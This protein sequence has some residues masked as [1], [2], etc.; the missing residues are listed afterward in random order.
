[1]R[2]FNGLTTSQVEQ[3]RKNF[4]ANELPKPKTATFWEKY[5]GNFNDPIITILLV[6]LGI[7]IIF[8][9]L[10][11]VELYEAGGILLA[12][13]ISTFVSTFSEYKNEG[14]FEK[15]QEKAGQKVC[16]VYR[17]GSLTEIPIESLVV[18]DFVWLCAGDIVPADGIVIDGC[19][20]VDQSPLN[21]EN[22]EIEKHNIF[23]NTDNTSPGY[24]PATIHSD[25]LDN[26]SVFRGSVVQSGEC[27]AE[28]KSVGGATVYG[29]MTHELGADTRKS[30]LVVKLTNLAKGISRFGYIGGI[31]IVLFFM[32]R[33]AIL[34]NNFDPYLISQYFANIPQVISD[35]VEAIIWGII[36]IV[37]AVPEGLPLMIAIVCSLNMNKMFKDNVLVRKLVGIETAGS[38][39]MLF[40]D[41]TGTITRGKLE[42]ISFTTGAGRC[43]SKF[44]DISGELKNITHMSVLQNNEA[45]LSV[46]FGGAAKI[47]GGNSTDKALLEY[48]SEKKS[49]VNVE[50]VSQIL[51]DSVRK[52]SAC[53]VSG[54]YNLSLIKGAPEVILSRCKSYYDINGA[55]VKISDF[56]TLDNEVNNLAK[57][58]IRVIALATSD[59]PLDGDVIP[60]NLTLVGLIGIRDEIR[61][62]VPSAVAEVQSA[63]VTVVMITGDRLDTATAIAKESGILR[64]ATDLALTSSQLAKM[65]DEKVKEILP[66]IRVIARAL[67]KDKS[68]LVRL[69]Q[70]LNLVVGMTG[71]GVNDSPALK[72]ADVG[73]AMGSGTD[74]AIQAGDIV[75]LDDNFLSIK[76]AILYGRTIYNNIKKFITF[77]LTINA[78]AVSIS[79][80]APMLGIERPLSI[81]QMLW[82]NLVMDALAAIAFGSEPSL[83]KYMKE[84][85][86]NRDENI[87]DKR[88]W[89]AIL[90]NSGFI[91]AISIFMFT[92]PFMH[93]LFRVHVGDIYF[94]TGYFTFFIF[95]CIFNAFNARAERSEFFENIA[96]NKNFIYVMSLVALVQVFMTYYGGVIL[97]TRGLVMPEWI[98][99]LSLAA[100]IIPFNMLR[101]ILI[102]RTHRF[103]VTKTA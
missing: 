78:A 83:A 61:R 96:A 42:V 101:K 34:A 64:Y 80:I 97:R 1:M 100:L 48:I 35:L 32:F 85:P 82:I 88:M 63:G 14:I 102:T 13:L 15:I 27:I 6:T 103:R 60:N 57:R 87:I 37:V 73:F 99:V 86:K 43:F 54:D 56:Y 49:D 26:F 62:E 65:P 77:Q 75:I 59:E 71:D 5:W 3:S 25:L 94:Y 24:A 19:V 31:F 81:T 41:K 36:I 8:V 53:K 7:N 45:K 23:G 39:N 79:L 28:I 90:W 55:K 29:S 47:I 93:S 18:G 89:S 72:R 50:K 12:V 2:T 66:R 70:E 95:A 22:A 46:G 9:F 30:P 84:K 33:E 11:K 92:S 52:F 4:G 67:P 44:S 17:N 76:R 21:G 68:R 20:A 40:T 16:K 58:A 98:V 91:F 74:V 51:F 38:L 69:A 10:G